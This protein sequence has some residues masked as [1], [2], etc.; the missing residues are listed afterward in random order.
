MIN[1]KKIKDRQYLGGIAGLVGG[2]C[3]VII[4]RISYSM[5]LSKRLYAET[6]SGVWVASKRQAQSISGQ[7]FGTLMTLYD[8]RFSKSYYPQ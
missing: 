4:D 1:L 3:M 5:G 6:A 8:G 7:V 2:L